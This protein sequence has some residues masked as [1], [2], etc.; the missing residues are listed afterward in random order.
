MLGAMPGKQMTT[1]TI[2]TGLL[3]TSLMAPVAHAASLL[4]VNPYEELD[5]DWFVEDGPVGARAAITFGREKLKAT[6]KTQ[7]DFNLS[8]RRSIF[9]Q[10]TDGQLVVGVDE[11][12]GKELVGASCDKTFGFDS[13]DLY[14]NLARSSGHA[15][16]KLEISW[17]TM[18][19]KAG[20]YLSS[21]DH[22]GLLVSFELPSPGGFSHFTGP[23]IVGDFSVTPAPEPAT[24]A[25]LG[26]GALAM[27]RRRKGG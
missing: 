21:G 6:T 3:V 22:K 14:Q 12:F 5:N 9:G 26:F 16:E 19:L 24:M 4:T 18:E 1:R 11:A 8:N 10:T 13:A 25:I 20:R 15:T 27:A 23:R 2:L 7:G 17:E